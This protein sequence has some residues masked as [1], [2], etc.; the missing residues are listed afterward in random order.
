[1]FA[2]T[3]S[4]SRPTSTW[5]SR[6]REG[7][8]AALARAQARAYL[9]TARGRCRRWRGPAP[10]CSGGTL[11]SGATPLCR[12]A[13]TRRPGSGP[14]GR[15]PRRRWPPPSSSAPS[16]LRNGNNGQSEQSVK[17]PQ[18]APGTLPLA[19]EQ[20]PRNPSWVRTWNKGRTPKVSLPTQT[21]LLAVSSRTK[22]K[23]PSSRDAIFWGPKRS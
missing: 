6:D 7:G 23:T 10:R 14:E 2:F 11:P 4:S 15:G 3:V 1:M 9:Q 21:F 8:V 17:A 12:W 18:E 22:A 5:S 13:S 19:S 16:G 20:T